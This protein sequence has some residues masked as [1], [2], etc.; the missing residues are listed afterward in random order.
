[1]MG[2]TE[3][4]LRDSTTALGNTLR[5]ADIPALRLPET[6]LRPAGRRWALSRAPAS[7]RLPASRPWL[8]PLAAA[9]SAAAVIGL[10]TVGVRALP[11]STS[12]QA[13]SS[14][15]SSSSLPSPGL[16]RYLV[17][18]IDGQA[19]VRATASGRLVTAIPRPADVYAY[20]GV[21][22]AAG[23][24][25]YFLAGV[26][27]GTGNWKVVFFKVV[28]GPDGRPG[29]VQ[30]LPGSPLAVPFP[31]IS[32]GWMNFYFAATSDG[33]E[34]A[35]A[36]GSPFPSG[37]GTPYGP[38]AASP[39]SNERVVVQNV[40]TG[41]R[42]MWGLWNSAEAVISQLSWGPGGHLGYDLTLADAGVSQARLILKVGRHVTAFMVLDTTAPGTDL[43][44]DSRVVSYRSSS[45]SAAG[46]GPHGVISPDGQHAYL[47]LPGGKTGGQIVEASAATGRT[48]RVL[49]TG[50]QAT[51]G[52][53]M[54]LD[55]SG[56]YLL[57]AL[58]AAPPREAGSQE[59]YVAG[60]L[61]RLDLRTGR[62][63]RLP[64]PVMAEINGAF[65]AAW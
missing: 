62:I 60:H 14:S 24:R 47:Q 50:P 4:R 63:A 59:A 44:G 26:M 36:S 9:A 3:E 8:V 13:A 37:A 54:S 52:E 51:I 12:G 16:P 32:G 56:R 5:E 21:A 29:Q 30:R 43:A 27:T 58:A 48:V 42:R 15:S 34:L 49:L 41:Q 39:G 23:D 11:G 7:R 64:I 38:A 45:G 35:Y 20:E 53:P 55:G 19:A 28:L 46:P 33:S 17:T 2:R 40:A 1:M 61:A 25:T 65:D 6:T 57:L 31:V 18:T 10:V 22:A